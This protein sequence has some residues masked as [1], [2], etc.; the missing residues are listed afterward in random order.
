MIRYHLVR[1]SGAHVRK[2]TKSNIRICTASPGSP[3][4]AATGLLASTMSAGDGV[5]G[6]AG[7]TG[8]QPPQGTRP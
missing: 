6:M 7:G 4:G 1:A 8:V 3:W 5:C 2:Y